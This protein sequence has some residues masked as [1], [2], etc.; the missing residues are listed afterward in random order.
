MNESDCDLELAAF[1]TE[2]C[3]AA[4]HHSAK[5][6]NSNIK[7]DSILGGLTDT[8]HRVLTTAAIIKAA[9]EKR[10]CGEH[11]RGWS[12]DKQTILNVVNELLK[13]KSAEPFES[14][15]FDPIRLAF[16]P[17]FQRIADS[18]RTKY[19][20]MRRGSRGKQNATETAIEYVIGWPEVMDA[21][22]RPDTAEERKRI[23]R[24]SDETGGPIKTKQGVSP[25][26][27]RQRLL[28]WW[29]SL[30][31]KWDALF[32][33]EESTA[34]TVADTYKYGKTGEVVPE[35]AGSVKRRRKT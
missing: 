12:A 7:G 15:L 32:A 20:G 13:S 16:V 24:M 22:G 21:I 31:A 34:A 29:A 9:T 25:R 19:Q 28:E 2:F 17:E 18:L 10:V 23:K 3:D 6:I 26:L 1:L 11:E 27:N 14:E 30:E 35:I 4:K 33:D 8:Y 5:A